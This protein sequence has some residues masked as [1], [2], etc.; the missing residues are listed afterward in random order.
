MS[1]STCWTRANCLRWTHRHRG[2]GSSATPWTGAVVDVWQVP[3]HDTL[4]GAPRAADQECGLCVRIWDAGLRLWRFTFHST[5]HGHLIHLYA[6]QIGDEIVMEQA[7]GGDLVPLDPL[8]HPA[9]VVSLA[10]PALGR[11]RR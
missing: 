11:R 6:R 5:A 3:G 9:G 2:Y 10:Q 8:R 7:E 4:A 1:I